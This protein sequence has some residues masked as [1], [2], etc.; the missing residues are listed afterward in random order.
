MVTLMF[1]LFVQ[2]ASARAA[3]GDERPGAFLHH[4]YLLSI[5]PIKFDDG[6][7]TYT[8]DAKIA[9]DPRNL[10]V[11]GASADQGVDLYFAEEDVNA[12]DRT[13]VEGVR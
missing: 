13:N 10:G 7:V 11:M 9:K 3:R 8:L 6:H 1:S 5:K 12:A 4:G 2:S